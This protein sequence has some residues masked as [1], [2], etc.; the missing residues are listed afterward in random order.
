MAARAQ[1]HFF[2]EA[3]TLVFRAPCRSASP[4]CHGESPGAWFPVSKS[5]RR[6]PASPAARP[7]AAIPL[8]AVTIQ[9][10]ARPPD[11]AAPAAIP[12]IIPA[13]PPLVLIAHADAALL[14]LACES[15]EAFLHCKVRTTSSALTAFDRTLQEPYRLLLIDLHL[16]DLHGELLYDLISRAYPR[17]HPG[18]LTAPPVFW[19]GTPADQPRQDQLTREARTKALLLTPLNIQR[20][21]AAA[22][23][24]LGEKPPGGSRAS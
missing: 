19:L 16:P 3:V 22:G 2:F 24:I 4:S 12:V 21:L 9:E 23:P 17:V 14:R 10:H 13:G 8:P 20:L 15:L 18:V 6:H 11:E 5:R 1:N 7:A